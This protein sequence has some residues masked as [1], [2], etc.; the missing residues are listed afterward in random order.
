MERDEIVATLRRIA[1]ERD[2]IAH[3]YFGI[4]QDILW[5]IIARHVPVLL[6]Q[7]R[8][9]LADTDEG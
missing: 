7:I 6:P 5:D 9:I 2:I 4:D 3:E 8:R 1:G